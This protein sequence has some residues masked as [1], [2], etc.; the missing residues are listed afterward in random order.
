MELV[1]IVPH[2]VVLAGGGLGILI[3]LGDVSNIWMSLVSFG[4]APRLGIGLG[5]SAQGFS[6]FLEDDIW[7]HLFSF[8]NSSRLSLV[9]FILQPLGLL[10]NFF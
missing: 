7:A 6:R 5:T 2:L 4:V 8:L 1:G 9:C 3:G 10:G